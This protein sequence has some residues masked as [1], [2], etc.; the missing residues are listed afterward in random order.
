MSP[1]C[2]HVHPRPQLPC[3]PLGEMLGA[4]S[5]QTTRPWFLTAGLRIPAPTGPQGGP[6]K[7][8]R[9]SPS[10]FPS[11]GWPGRALSFRAGPRSLPGIRRPLPNPQGAQGASGSRRARC[12][13]GSRAGEGQRGTCGGEAAGARAGGGGRASWD[14]VGVIP[15]RAL[16][17]GRP[18]SPSRGA[19]P[20]K[21]ARGHTRAGQA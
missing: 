8:G 12:T 2:S 9:G 3:G 17:F 6:S 7:R 19:G 21:R 14:Q 1:S 11:A 10:P 4:T 20:F 15:F 18:W 13:G 5:V 16:S